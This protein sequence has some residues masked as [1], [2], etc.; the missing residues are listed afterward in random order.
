MVVPAMLWARLAAR[1]AL[2]VKTTMWLP[3]T[4]LARHVIRM[5]ILAQQRQREHAKP[6]ITVPPRQVPALLVLQIPTRLL[7]EMEQLHY[8]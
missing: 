5:P 8:V 1:H 4:V 3:V 6:D 2:Q 7:L